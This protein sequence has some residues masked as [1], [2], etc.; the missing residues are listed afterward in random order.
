[1]KLTLEL[2]LGSLS[3]GSNDLVVG[4]A[5][6]D[7]AGQVNNGD[8]GSW[9]THGHA[10]ELAVEVWNDLAD[11]LGGTSRGWDDVLGRSTASTP[12]LAGWTIDGLLGGGV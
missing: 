8:V 7:A 11:S 9:H 10:G 5:L 12:V 4:G 3:Q 2:A 6:L 1:M